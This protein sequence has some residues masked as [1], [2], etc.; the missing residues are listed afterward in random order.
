M[1]K[2]N[3][4]DPTDANTWYWCLDHNAAEPDDSNCPPN[5]RIGPY[6]SKPDAEHWRARVDQR[7]ASWDAADRR[8]ENDEPFDSPAVGDQPS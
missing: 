7:N 4:I 6:A 3:P 1:V 5:S 8:W 2:L